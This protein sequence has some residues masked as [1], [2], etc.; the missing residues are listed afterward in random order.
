MLFF[1][2]HRETLSGAIRLG[3]EGIYIDDA[4]NPGAIALV[5]LSES[6]KSWAAV[7]IPE[8][9]SDKLETANLS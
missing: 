4:G 9:V 7:I 2:R 1:H 6:R 5:F 3:I 8:S